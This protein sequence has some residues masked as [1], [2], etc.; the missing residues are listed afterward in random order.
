D[1]EQKYAEDA[2][3]E[4]MN[5]NARVWRTYLDE[6]SAYDAGMVDTWRDGLD[7]LLVFAGLFSAVVSAFVVQTSQRLSVD[8]TKVTA[9]L[10]LQVL[11]HDDGDTAYN[12]TS[13]FD[14]DSDFRPN[15]LDSWVNGLWFVSLTLSLTTAAAAV[16]TK[17]WIHEF[18]S[19]PSGSPRDRS[20]IRQFRY[21]GLQAWR[22]P[23][24][25]G[26]LPMLMHLSLALFF[27]GMVV[28][29]YPL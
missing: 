23:A 4:E 15:V 10:L 27:V 22:V 14:I 29:L 9:N 20:R 26:F 8:Y 3:Y 1:Y 12:G 24:I 7:V 16:L 21:T 11:A 2:P 18:M 13:Y 28:F 6:C 5:P 25:I 17:Q 19:V